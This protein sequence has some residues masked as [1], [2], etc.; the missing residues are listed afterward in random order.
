MKTIHCP[1]CREPLSFAG[2]ENVKLAEAG[3]FTGVNGEPGKNE[4]KVEIYA[5]P[6]CGKLEFFTP[7]EKEPV[8][9][10]TACPACG[11]AYDADFPRC[12]S[13]GKPNPKMAGK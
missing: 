3:I 1:R 2:S 6:K 13:C 8:I 12:P 9:A 5:C 4:L 7:T 11:K 10:K